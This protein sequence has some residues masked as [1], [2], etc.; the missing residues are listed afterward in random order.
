MINL[1]LTLREVRD[2]PEHEFEA[3]IESLR[4]LREERHGRAEA[5]LSAARDSVPGD[6][7]ERAEAHAAWSREN[8]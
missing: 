7:A 8:L 4:D 6:L 5:A 1:R 3:A 2:L